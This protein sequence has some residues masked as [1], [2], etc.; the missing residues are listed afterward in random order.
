MAPRIIREPNELRAACDAVRMQGKRVGL[1]P[2]MGALHD[3]HL[4]LIREGR[5]RA[6]VVAATIF[7]NPSQ[8]GP[9][10][11]YAR[12]PRRLEEDAALCPKHGAHAVFAPE[13]SATFKVNVVAD[14]KS[15]S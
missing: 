14:A 12:Y 10:E 8:F 7:V 1:V 11:D 15:A 3:G 2:T 5:T 13:V 6:D 9:N 4:S